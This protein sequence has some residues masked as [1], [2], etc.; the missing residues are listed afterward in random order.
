MARHDLPPFWDGW[1][2]VWEGWQAQPRVFVCPPP[3][4]QPCKGCGSF[5]ETITNWGRAWCEPGAVVPYRRPKSYADAAYNQ[6]VAREGAVMLHLFA[7]RC[8]DCRRD[9]VMSM[10]SNVHDVER[11]WWDLD[12]SDYGDAGS[13]GLTQESLF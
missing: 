5:A 3:K 12:E 2:V 1:R 4:P 6:Q 11:E 8:P 10:G 7:F 13:E 9:E